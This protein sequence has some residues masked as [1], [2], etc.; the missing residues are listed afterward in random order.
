[1]GG[2]PIFFQP[3]TFARHAQAVDRVL[4]DNQARYPLSGRGRTTSPSVGAWGSLASGDTI[5]AASGLTLGGGT[6]KLC[7]RSGGTLTE[8]SE[9]VPVLNSGG[10]I[11]GPAALPLRWTDGDWA[12]CQCGG[13]NCTAGIC[14][15]LTNYV[16]PFGTRDCGVC[17]PDGCATLTAK[18]AGTVLFTRTMSFDGF[19]FNNQAD[20][21][22]LTDHFLGAGG[23]DEGTCYDILSFFP[24]GVSST[25]GT[26]AVTTDHLTILGGVDSDDSGWHSAFG[27]DPYSCDDDG[28]HA[29][30]ELVTGLGGFGTGLATYQGVTD[31][32]LDIAPYPASC[33]VLFNVTGC[34][35]LAVAGATVDIW[36]SSA[37]TT[38]V[39][40]CTTDALGNCY[41]N[42]GNTFFV[43]RYYEVAASR[44][45]TASAT[46][47]M[48]PGDVITPTLTPASGYHC[49]TGCALPLADTLHATHPTFGALA[50][51]YNGSGS[52]GA[53][54]YATTSYS[55]P[56][57][58]CCPSKT[59]TATSFLDTSLGFSDHWKSK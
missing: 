13:C 34:N 49:A 25:P 37:K 46:L 44:F 33:A 30:W 24:Q 54:W 55:Y 39:G 35:G 58:R 4:G 41:I 12:V 19:S 36:T 27:V 11:S 23:V 5:T 17:T 43:S 40:T 42:I 57:C 14:A 32:Y 48:S 16:T 52:L 29:H 31:L 26:A 45:T 59:V 9:T 53:G 20:P 18:S 10:V 8:T 3:K 2:G 28:F 22:F 47:S 21:I 15:Q 7:T 38:H 1:M 51:A 50:L 6:V 56:G